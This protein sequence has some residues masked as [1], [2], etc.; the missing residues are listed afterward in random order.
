MSIIQLTRELGAAIQED[1]RY[2]LFTE[3]RTENAK[4]EEL[5]E[6]LGKINLIQLSYQH[7]AKKGDDANEQKMEAY[8]AEFTEIYNEIIKNPNMVKY[9]T[10]RAAVDDMMNYIIQILS[11]CVNGED[12]K[13]CEPKKEEDYCDSGN[14]S[15]CSGCADFQ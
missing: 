8:N 14:C 15:D 11:L 2:L 5:T 7:E 3:A 10:A 12:P 13:T 1:E 4:D 9:E 6:L